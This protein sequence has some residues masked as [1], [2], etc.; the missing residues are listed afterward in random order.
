[1]AKILQ[2]PTHEPIRE[3]AYYRFVLFRL[4]SWIMLIYPNYCGF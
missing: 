1:M 3:S 4:V 2:S